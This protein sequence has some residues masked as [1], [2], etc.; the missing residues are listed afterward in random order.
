[1]FQRTPTFI[2]GSAIDQVGS[3]VVLAIKIMFLVEFLCVGT[4]NMDYQDLEC[5]IQ[6]YPQI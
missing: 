1:M 6:V 3:I 5:A 4:L 2:H